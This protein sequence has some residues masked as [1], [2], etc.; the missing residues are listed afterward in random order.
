M[1][2]KTGVLISAVQ[3]S[4]PK[5]FEKASF[6]GSRQSGKTSLKQ[7]PQ[8]NDEWS[9]ASDSGESEQDDIDDT[10][11]NDQDD[12]DEPQERNEAS[13]SE[14]ENED[15]DSNAGSQSDDG[16][17]TRYSLEQTKKKN[18]PNFDSNIPLF[19]LLAQAKAKSKP[20]SAPIEYRRHFEIN[21]RTRKDKR[22]SAS[23]NDAS[24]DE[25]KGGKKR[26]HA[27]T[28]MRSDKPVRRL[29]VEAD[30]STRKFI[31]PRYATNIFSPAIITISYLYMI[32]F[33]DFAGKLDQRIYAKNYHFLE[34]NRQ[35]E[36]DMLQKVM[37]KAKKSKDASIAEDVHG[38]IVK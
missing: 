30:N 12:H 11:V 2:V 7:N 34:E 17:A 16:E 13:E 25:E 26:K 6:Q 1:K 9:S 20:Y 35:Q 3:K 18:K 21:D 10:D 32:R 14:T 38:E 31:D 27:P 23:T 4:T 15:S 33:A 29:R 19:K 22:K 5:A 28:E 37:K 8:I 24:S 36:I